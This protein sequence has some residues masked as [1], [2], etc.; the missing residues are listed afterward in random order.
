MAKATKSRK[1]DKAGSKPGAGGKP[2]KA[3]TGVSPAGKAVKAAKSTK[4]GNAA[5][6]AATAKAAPKSARP[7]VSVAGAKIVGPG[8]AKKPVVR[9]IE[10]DGASEISKDAAPA[11][12]AKVEAVAPRASAVIEPPQAAER[13]GTPPALPVPIASFTF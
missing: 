11:A 13:E 9:T 10:G 8:G 2:H 4:T 1:P 12:A 5:P 6:S 3:A 7:A